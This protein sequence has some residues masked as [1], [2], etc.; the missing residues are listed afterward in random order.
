[1]KSHFIPSSMLISILLLAGCGSDTLNDLECN[2]DD[3]G[4]L[5]LNCDDACPNNPNISSAEEKADNNFSCDDITD[6]CQNGIKDD[7]EDDVD[8]GGK[9]KKCKSNCGNGSCDDGETPENCAI[10]CSS[11]VNK[12]GNGSCDDGENVT[13]CPTDCTCGNRICDP[14]ESYVSCS[15][16]C[17]CGNGICD[18]SET[19]VSCSTDC[20]YCVLND[21]SKKMAFIYVDDYYAPQTSES[22]DNFGLTQFVL[23]GTGY[24]YWKDRDP[25]PFKK[26]I[27]S[28]VKTLDTIKKS[29]RGD[30]KRVWIATPQSKATH[31]LDCS[32]YPDQISE[33]IQY[34]NDLREAIGAEDWNTYVNGIYIYDEAVYGWNGC[35]QTNRNS[36]DEFIKHPQVKTF[37]AIS[38]HVRKPYTKNG[39]TWNAKQMLWA[40]YYGARTVEPPDGHY[41]NEGT[42]KHIE[43]IGFMANRTDIFDIILL[44]PM[45]YFRG[46]IHNN[47]YL[48]NL[49]AIRNMMQQQTV[50]FREYNGQF[51]AALGPKTSKTKI[52][53][54]MEIDRSYFNGGLTS[55]NPQYETAICEEASSFQKR[56]HEY[57]D[58]ISNKIDPI[59]NY[60]MND[61][62]VSYY[63]EAE[64]KNEPS[65]CYLSAQ[66]LECT[67]N[68]CD[69]H[70]KDLREIVRKFQGVTPF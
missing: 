52:G 25:A 12:C 34:V 26:R 32:N 28:Y 63:L 54:Q 16:D 68:K 24:G 64:F 51:T 33:Y 45:Y 23:T 14:G 69:N 57:E 42:S 41:S 11:E 2:K 17:T 18:K 19:A 10:D 20:H 48:A 8:C 62:Y 46:S 37:K 21:C 67:N 70:A 9:C 65:T 56:Y 39:K 58:Y 44:Q 15:D 38:D 47:W 49:P 1:M 50:T 29:T 31:D 5:T 4:D 22:I 27:A 66:T 43:D 13:S 6:L 61:Y 30:I 3:D 60:N 55:V 35:F 59:S 53:V 36:Y 7:G 40:P